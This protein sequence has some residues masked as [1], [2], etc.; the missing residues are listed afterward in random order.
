MAR[1]V[2]EPA[3][4][5]AEGGAEGAAVAE[6]AGGRLAGLAVVDGELVLAH[7]GVVL[8]AAGAVGVPDLAPVIAEGRAGR[9]PVGGFVDE[10]DSRAAVDVVEPELALARA[11]F[12]GDHVVAVGG[13]L[14]GLIGAGLAPR[15]LDGVALV[16]RDDV[17]RFAAAAVGGEDDARAVGA[18]ARLA[19][20]GH[21]PGERSGGAAGDGQGVE[22]AEE[23]EDEGLA[24]GADVDRHPRAF[25]EAGRDG[26]AGGEGEALLLRV[27][28]VVG[29]LCGEGEWD[30]NDHGCAQGGRQ[31]Q[32]NAPVRC[33]EHHSCPG[34]SRD[35]V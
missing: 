15:D 9:A 21:A 30:G 33:G 23:V 24:V 10:L 31:E 25:G 3:P 5:R 4:V 28:V 32:S 16:E 34:K 18:E 26:A 35:I 22:V 1:T 14:G 17:D 12:G 27:G 8:P 29:V 7:P 13:P 6:G 2:D 19:V 20:E 11:L